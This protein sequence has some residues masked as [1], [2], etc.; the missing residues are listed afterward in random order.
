MT[1]NRPFL[2]AVLLQNVKHAVLNNQNVF[3]HLSFIKSA[4][5]EIF[6]PSAK[7]PL[8]CLHSSNI[9]IHLF[10]S[11]D[12]WSPRSTTTSYPI[13]CILRI[14]Q[15]QHSEASSPVQILLSYNRYF[16]LT[17]TGD[18]FGITTFAPARIPFS[19]PSGWIVPSAVVAGSSTV[20]WIRRIIDSSRK[21]ISSVPA[22]SFP[23]GVSA[24]GI[25]GPIP[26]I[27]GS[28]SL[29]RQRSSY[30]VSTVCMVN[31]P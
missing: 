21:V 9:C 19:L 23:N 12:G 27:S 7:K 26:H 29:I 24:C 1:E 15:P 5:T 31:R 20:G 16:F 13:P 25:K 30:S 17:P 6:S 22:A 14:I 3:Q 28:S 2:F 10:L 11:Y 18:R 4:I 8:P